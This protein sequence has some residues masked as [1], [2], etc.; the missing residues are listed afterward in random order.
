MPMLSG[1]IQFW[2]L[3]PT[4]WEPCLLALKDIGFEIVATYLSWRRFEPAHRQ[5]DFD[6]RTDPRLN[7]R[8]FLDLCKKHHLLVHL[9]PG[10]WICAE[11][12]NGGYPDW[13]I[14]HSELLSLDSQGKVI[15]GYN[16]PFRAPIPSYAHPLYRSYA[17]E[18]LEAI[19]TALDGYF[20]PQGPIVLVQLDNEPSMT[21]HD[22]L[23]EGDYNSSIVAENG[24]YPRWLESRYPDKTPVSSA[25]RAF[26]NVSPQ[27]LFDWT[28]FKEFLLQDHIQFLKQ[29][30]Q[31]QQPLD[32]LFTLNLN[33]HPQ[34]ATPNNWIFLQQT[35]DSIGYDYY[36]IPPFKWQDCVNMAFAISYSQTV[37]PLV[38]APELMA[39][40]WISPGVDEDHPGF[41]LADL[42]FFQHSAFAL[43]LKGANFYMAVNR[44]N[45]ADA[46]ITASGKP[47]STYSSVKNLIHLLKRIPNYFDLQKK[48]QIGVV[49]SHRDAR[50]D[51]ILS[52]KTPGNE[53]EDGYQRFRAMFD[54]LFTANF[55]PAIIDFDLQPA[56]LDNFEAIF[57]TPGEDFEPQVGTQLL[58]YAARGGTLCISTADHEQFLA[59]AGKFHD[60]TIAESQCYGQ[61]RIVLHQPITGLESAGNI[62]A[63]LAKLSIRP[64]ISPAVGG[65]ITTIHENDAERVCFVLNAN[66]TTLDCEFKIQDPH[67]R[68]WISLMG[69]QRSFPVEHNR[70]TLTL[71]AR[72]VKAFRLR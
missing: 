44:E 30:F 41:E 18:W 13:L 27:E 39:G 64:E 66:N 72:S 56:H 54:A 48:S 8:R 34:L 43:G 32:V 15:Q 37:A 5:F 21:F 57:F 46:P 38:W 3:D 12:T 42:A 20:Y 16:P 10:P 60:L 2:R 45:W 35:C 4:D 1:E 51:Y 67:V 36:F 70:L 61:G 59:A 53:A 9:K 71:P 11:E 24:L 22:R 68:E 6:G 31:G 63:W 62:S 58:E 14:E 52:A 69:D 55:N 26:D 17:R 65:V 40:I 19:R 28:E 47:G 33:D 25:P 50:Q 23:F 29:A 7:V 49:F